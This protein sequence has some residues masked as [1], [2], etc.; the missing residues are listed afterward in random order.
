[1][2]VCQEDRHI[3]DHTRTSAVITDYHAVFLQRPRYNDC[4]TLTCTTIVCGPHAPICPRSSFCTKPVEIGDM[5]TPRSLS[6]P[7]A[8]RSSRFVPVCVRTAVCCFAAGL[9]LRQVALQRIYTQPNVSIIIIIA[10]T[11]LK[12]ESSLSSCIEHGESCLFMHALQNATYV[13]GKKLCKL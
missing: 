10:D 8:A 12:P 1:M 4:D 2:L 6:L 5:W 3:E 9:L 11:S 7:F 13:I